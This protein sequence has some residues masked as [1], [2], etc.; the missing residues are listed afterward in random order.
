MHPLISKISFI[1]FISFLFLPQRSPKVIGCSGGDY[2]DLR[3]SSLFI[4]EMIPTNRF[5]PFF[6]SIYDYYAENGQSIPGRTI[7]E[8]KS[9]DDINLDEW[10]TYFTGLERGQINEIVYQL[11][12][13]AMD[14]MT[15]VAQKK[16]SNPMGIYKNAIGKSQ[17]VDG[18]KYLKFAKQIEKAVYT[19]PWSWQDEPID[20]IS[21][22]KLRIQGLKDFVSCKSDFLKLRYGFQVARLNYALGKYA[23]GIAFVEKNYPF[24][25]EQGFM[26][27][28]THGYEA[29]CHVRLKNYPKANLWYA[30]LYDLGE[31]YKIE[32]YQSFHPQNDAE[33]AQT[34]A[35]A[36]TPRDKELLWHLFGVYADPIRGMQEIAKINPNSDL[37]PLL[38]VRA[39]NIAEFNVSESLNNVGN[40]YAFITQENIPT[41]FTPD[42][43][44]SWSSIKADRIVL[45]RETIESIAPKR[46]EDQSIWLMSDAFVYW[47]TGDLENC[48][49]F[50]S[51]AETLGK[52]NFMIQGQAAIHKL[53]VRFG[54]VK[55][56]QAVDEA[57]ILKL[58][59][60]L[61]VGE[62][63]V[64]RHAN[65]L[66]YVL[67]KMKPLY[68]QQEDFIM[69]ELVNPD[70]YTFYD[71]N[72]EV[73][74]MIDFM[75]KPNHSPFRQFIIERYPLKIE[76]LYDIQAVGMIYQYK[77]DEAANIYKK[78]P[79]AGLDTL[80]G[81]PFNMSIVDCHD[82]D[83][84]KVQKMKYSK[85]TFVEKM[86]ELKSKGD[87][88]K[89][90]K[91]RAN[92]YYLFANGLYNMTYYGNARLVSSTPVNWDFMDSNRFSGYNDEKRP[93]TSYYDC[94]MAETYYLKALEISTDKEFRAK[95]MWMAAKCEHNQWLESSYVYNVTGDFSAGK[96]FAMMKQLYSDSKY[97]QE[98]IN[99]CG[100][101][102][103]YINPGQKSCIK[104]QE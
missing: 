16:V 80:L 87:K 34:L 36:E 86:I 62:Y 65:A 8:G 18:F 71:S 61:Q 38:L 42:P 79:K 49:E 95:M 64:E 29:A 23:D 2:E 55:Q 6:L 40:E 57:E 72:E 101:F 43:L 10:S 70:I 9:Q 67:R 48:L 91:E 47:L 73:Q 98:V 81:N 19:N 58:I 53:L 66:N 14:S 11:S 15:M 100:Y 24:T 104:N 68:E 102:C 94:S 52:N 7:V 96:H 103:Q 44:F 1:L 45:L 13:A 3:A 92:N 5:D 85:R 22:E 12:A 93:T 97:F 51:A 4:P 74:G 20:T 54:K 63:G 30:R 41:E 77:F 76:E 50:T 60:Q 31:T 26:Y 39:V 84:A 89:D 33:W 82:C 37:L 59:T 21:L 75:L 35:L 25:P 28:R 69:A 17:W 90:P 27:F 99:E 88:E 56:I 32:A 83:H 78:H 46:K